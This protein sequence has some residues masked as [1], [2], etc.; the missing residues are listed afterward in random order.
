MIL[1]STKVRGNKLFAP[2]L[3][4]F[5]QLLYAIV[6]VNRIHTFILPFKAATEADLSRQRADLT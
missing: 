6:G 3:Y 2:L 1:T 5:A 4:A